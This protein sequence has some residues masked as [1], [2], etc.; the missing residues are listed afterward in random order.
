MRAKD[1]VLGSDLPGLG[2]A[3]TLPDFIPLTG[4]VVLGGISWPL[5]A[6]FCI[7][8]LL[9]YIQVILCQRGGRWV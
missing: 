3:L 7:L 5:G 6:F 9:V 8:I 1:Y 4:L 2:R